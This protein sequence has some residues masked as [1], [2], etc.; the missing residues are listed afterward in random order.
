LHWLTQVL[1]LLLFC[2]VCIALAAN[3]MKAVG[4]VKGGNARKEQMAEGAGGDV[5]AAYAEMGS[6][7]GTCC[8]STAKHH[9]LVIQQYLAA[10]DCC[11]LVLDVS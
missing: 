4:G 11:K 2:P 8:G 5:H 3:E 1:A 9:P 10:F 7:V 6:K